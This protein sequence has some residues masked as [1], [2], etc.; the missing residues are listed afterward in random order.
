V[1]EPDR[2]VEIFYN[3]LRWEILT[4]VS[5][6]APTDPVVDTSAFVIPCSDRLTPIPTAP[7]IMSWP[8]PYDFLLSEVQA[9]LTSPAASGTFTVDLEV[10]GSSI[11]STPITIDAGQQ[12]SIGAAVA[13]VIA[14]AQ[15]LKGDEVVVAVTDD[16]DGT[17]SGLIVTLVGTA[18]SP[19]DAGANNLTDDGGNR[20]IDNAANYLV[21]A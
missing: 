13:A 21:E 18:S 3:G 14:T 12:S 16:A 10:G 7:D 15:L 4:Q 2:S 19:A 1:I 9:Y 11:L 8:M 17:A 20:Y 6:A 5:D